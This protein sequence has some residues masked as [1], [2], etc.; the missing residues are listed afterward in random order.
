MTL[1]A[2]PDKVWRVIGYVLLPTLF[3][4]TLML[5]LYRIR[6]PIWIVLLLLAATST[7]RVRSPAIKSRSSFTFSSP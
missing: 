7:L 4:L 6:L 2:G 5:P 1:E 3:I